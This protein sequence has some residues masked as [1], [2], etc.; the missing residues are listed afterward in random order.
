MATVTRLPRKPR[1]LTKT[2]QPDAPYV[3]RREDQEDGS[4]TFEIYDERPGSYRLVCSLSD[5]G[6]ENAYARH[7]AD[8]VARALNFMLRLG[9]ER[10]PRV[11]DVD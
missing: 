2:Y 7:D 11:R 8:Q 4:I 6:G 10:L 5:D 9:K 1:P 3:V